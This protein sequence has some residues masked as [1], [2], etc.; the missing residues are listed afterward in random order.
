MQSIPRPDIETEASPSSESIHTTEQI[1]QTIATVSEGNADNSQGSSDHKNTSQ[2]IPSI[3]HSVQ[4]T[5]RML[6]RLP[7][8]N[9]LNDSAQA[10]KAFVWTTISI[11]VAALVFQLL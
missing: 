5:E 2:K 11:A 6:N 9:A 7:S 3:D 10:S 4:S 8:A 1:V